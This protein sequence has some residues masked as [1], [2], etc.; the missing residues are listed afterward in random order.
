MNPLAR[1]RVDPLRQATVSTQR[2]EGTRAFA[3][4]DELVVE[5]PLEIRVGSDTNP[6]DATAET[7][8]VIMR[9]PGQ[10]IELAAGFLYT[11]GLIAGRG[12]I[13]AIRPGL[14]ADRLPSDNIL[15]VIPQPGVDLRRRAREEGYSR[16]FA[17]NASCGICGKNTVAA[18]CATLPSLPDDDFFVTPGV[19]YSLPDTLRAGQQV[20]AQT[21]GLHAAGIFDRAG[22][23]IALREDIGRHNAVDKLVGQA[24]L[25]G[26]LP[27]A[28]RIVMVSGRLSFEIVLKAL[29]GGIPI[30]AAV[31]AP[32]SLAIDLAEAGGVTLV[33]FLRGT[34]AN[35]YT[36]PHRIRAR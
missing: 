34:A 26:A 1:S 7:L 20:F 6:D 22:N 2:W 25:D 23:L 10:D 17:V 9:T 27:L 33:A 21:G 16:K 18:A 8:A 15:D 4:Q 36:H 19:L 11:E 35:V 12:E 28:R 24:M 5:E 14:D 13:S 30:I 29:A 3:H 32:S 31:S